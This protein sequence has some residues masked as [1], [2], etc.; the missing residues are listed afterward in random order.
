VSGIATARRS[1]PRS[2]S[3]VSMTFF[4]SVPHA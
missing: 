4:R 1:S 3:R 2:D